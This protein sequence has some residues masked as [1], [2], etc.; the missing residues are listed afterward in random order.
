M[1]AP[2]NNT[3]SSAR[4]RT[5][6]LEVIVASFVVD[7]PSTQCCCCEN[8]V[9]LRHVADDDVVD[10]EKSNGDATESRR[11]GAYDFEDF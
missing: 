11:G 10:A 9:F 7:D 2:H 6:E 1:G 4:T 5:F 3:V 8:V